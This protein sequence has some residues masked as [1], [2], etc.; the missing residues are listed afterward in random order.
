M[1]GE[2]GKSSW[3]IFDVL[4]KKNCFFQKKERVH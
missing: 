4:A 1:E 2:I 3:K